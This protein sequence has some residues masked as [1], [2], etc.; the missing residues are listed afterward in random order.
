MYVYASTY[1]KFSVL[2]FDGYVRESA[3]GPDHSRIYYVFDTVL[4]MM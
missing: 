3:S 1:L 4:F 2:T